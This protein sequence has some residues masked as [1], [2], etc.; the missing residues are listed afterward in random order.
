MWIFFTRELLENE[1]KFCGNAE[2]INFAE[3]RENCDMS[4]SD[5]E[6]VIREA[7][8]VSKSH[9]AKWYVQC[10]LRE[11][12]SLIASQLKQEDVADAEK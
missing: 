11:R 6:K 5:R 8:D 7:Q 2:E 4:L 9:S 1:R 10:K 12:E 3:S